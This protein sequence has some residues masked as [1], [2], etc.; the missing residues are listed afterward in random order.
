MKTRRV[1]VVVP[2][3]QPYVRGG[4]ENLY[5]GLSAAIASMEHVSCD[6]VAVPSPEGTFWDL[7][8]SYR[9]FSTLNLSSYECVISTKYP[10]WM[11]RHENHI[12]YMLHKLR[13]LYDTYGLFQLPEAVD[14][15]SL[16]EKSRFAEAKLA[17]AAASSVQVVGLIDELLQLEGEFAKHPA[18]QLPSPFSRAVVHWLD[19]FGLRPSAVR[20]YFA[21]SK[22]VVGREGYFPPAVHVEAVYPDTALRT[23]S[24]GRFDYFFTASR[25]DG[26]K[27]INLIIEAFKGV[28]GD[29]RLLIAGTGPDLDRLRRLAASEQRIELLGHVSDEALADYYANARCVVFTPYDE[30]LGYITIEA[31]RSGKPVITTTDSGGPTEFIVHGVNGFVVAPDKREV[32]AAMQALVDDPARAS[33]MGSLGPSTVSH[34]QWEG[35]VRRLL[36]AA[37]DTQ[38]LGRDAVASRPKIVLVST[39]PVF[40]PRGGGQARIFHVWR[41]VA[42]IADVVLVCSVPSSEAPLDC[43]IA[44]GFREVRVPRSKDFEDFEIELSRSVDWIPVTDIAHAAAPHLAADLRLTCAKETADAALL[45]LEHPYLSLV[46]KDLDLPV[47]WYESHNHEAVMKAKMLP[48]TEAGHRALAVVRECEALACKL[49]STV[50]GVSEADLEGFRSEGW[51]VGHE[52]MLVPNGVDLDSVG[53]TAQLERRALRERLGFGGSDV[54]LILA[55]WHGPNLEAVESLMA[56]AP[57][58]T[59]VVF[60]VV[61]SAGEAF[62]TRAVPENVLFL[63]A[64]TDEEKNVLLGSAS[65]AINPMKS[66]G[67]SNLKLFD[68]LASGAPTITSEFGARGSGI[69]AS[70]AWIFGGDDFHEAL[71]AALAEVLAANDDYLAAKCVAARAHVEQRYD[72]R[73]LTRPILE[74]IDHLGIRQVVCDTGCSRGQS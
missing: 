28:V 16:P 59:G 37:L 43:L 14:Y 31:L 69:D 74:A 13:G 35:A 55:S 65:V 44:P 5:E 40:P 33:A 25:L 62:K 1:A 36:S 9:A 50:I 15:G 26:P 17:R 71:Y 11:L 24:S 6:V 39:Y 42:E 67:G 2:V 72:W 58:F 10:S 7:L 18:F 3:P 57:R 51:L 64:V 20:G 54:A 41:H 12:C 30:D 46:V 48:D 45:V 23:E 47:V 70:H 27:R 19:D 73:V 68:Y 29:V 61:G 34:V 4:A 66:G 53:F 56:V 21:I 32:A 52:A 63:G 8:R 22:T 49:A 60:L 38:S